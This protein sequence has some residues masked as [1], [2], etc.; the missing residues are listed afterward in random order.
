MAYYNLDW[1][2]AGRLTLHQV[3]RIEYEIEANEVKHR[4]V[5]F[6][7]YELT[8]DGYQLGKDRQDR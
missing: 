2:F 7:G 1:I 8:K 4:T 3:Y 6:F 5:M